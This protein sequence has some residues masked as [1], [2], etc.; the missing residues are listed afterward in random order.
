MYSVMYV[1][2][3]QYDDSQFL[4]DYSYEILAL[5]NISL[6]LISFLLVCTS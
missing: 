4:K 1:T 5:Y 3:L 2:G 6:S